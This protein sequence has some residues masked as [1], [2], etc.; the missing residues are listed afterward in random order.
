MNCDLP[1]VEEGVN[2]DPET[3]T[4]RATF[5]SSTTD[6]SGAVVYALAEVCDTGLTDLDPLFDI[7][8]PQ[9]LDRVCQGSHGSDCTVEFTYHDHRVRV[10]SYGIIE[11]W[12]DTED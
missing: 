9:A 10:K 12:P 1:D 3:E 8:D 4:Y 2:Y 5:A 6:P 11:V 7:L